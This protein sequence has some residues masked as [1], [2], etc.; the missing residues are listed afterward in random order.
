M[1]GASGIK[2]GVPTK[3]FTNSMVNLAHYFPR[4]IVSDCKSISDLCKI[5]TR[6]YTSTDA[7]GELRA[8]RA[9]LC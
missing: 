2:L 8:G 7:V 9:K 6:F 5:V 3:L 4:E 1:D